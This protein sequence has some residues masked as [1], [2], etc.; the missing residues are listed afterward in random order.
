MGSCTLSGCSISY[1]WL[2]QFYACLS[3]L[4]SL[5]VKAASVFFANKQW[6]ERWQ[7]EKSS[8]KCLTLLELLVPT[9]PQ[10]VKT[11]S[12]K[13][14]RGLCALQVSFL[15]LL[16]TLHEAASL[17]PR[18]LMAPTMHEECPSFGKLEVPFVMLPPCAVWLC[19][20]EFWKRKAFDIGHKVVSS[21]RLPQIGKFGSFFLFFGSKGEPGWLENLTN[22]DQQK[23][24][25]AESGC[26]DLAASIEPQ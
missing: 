25:A 3:L 26:G 22:L 9:D 20:D 2:I 5:R 21:R 19:F 23:P 11:T 16:F 15:V 8:Y 24:G 4:P 12:S 7:P 14:Q 10:E 18:H 6:C 17:S 13:Y 1:L